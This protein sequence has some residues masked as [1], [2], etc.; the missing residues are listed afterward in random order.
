[1]AGDE[2]TDIVRFAEESYKMFREGD[3]A[4]F[5]RVDPDIEWH[6]FEALPGGGDIHGMSALVD[7]LEAMNEKFEEAFPDPEEFVPLGE[8][9]LLVMG[10]WRAKVKTTGEPV[11][12]AFAHVTKMR[13]GKLVELR[14]YM[15]SAKV[16]QALE[17]QRPT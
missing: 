7:H 11:E 8:D 13:D 14:N 17:E 2:I 3:L 5:D 12:V 15:D 16:L 9:R 6:A 4:W 10:T 1:M